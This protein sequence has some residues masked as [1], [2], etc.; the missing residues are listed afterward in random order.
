[1][2]LDVN[3]LLNLIEEDPD[4]EYAESDEYNEESYDEDTEISSE[5]AASEMTVGSSAL[6]ETAAYFSAF[7]QKGASNSPT[8]ML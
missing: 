7:F 8:G 2:R 4:V 6:A 5:D 1:M 3:G